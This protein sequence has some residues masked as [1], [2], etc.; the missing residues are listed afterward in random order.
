MQNSGR[1]YAEFAC[2]MEKLIYYAATTLLLISLSYRAFAAIDP[3]STENT[4]WQYAEHIRAGEYEKARGDALRLLDMSV[5]GKDTSTQMRACSLI[6]QSY[7]ATDQYDSTYRYFQMGMRLW[8]SMDSLSRTDDA[9]KAMCVIYNGL[10]IYSISVERNYERAISY[11]LSGLRLTDKSKEMS[12]YYAIFGSNLVHSYYLLS[13][14]TGLDY[15]MEVYRHGKN[16]EDPYILHAG[17]YS[18]ALMY[19]LK[20]DTDKALTFLGE[21]F[22]DDSD[23]FYKMAVYCLYADLL[24]AKGD[25]AEALIWYR[26]ALANL[27][28]NSVT[29]SISVYKSYGEFLTAQGRYGEAADILEAGVRLAETSGNKVYTYRLYELLSEDYDSLGQYD[30]AL[31]MF[32]KFYQ[33]TSDINL[34]EQERSVS[35]LLRKYENEKH[36][37][38]IQE[39]NLVIM[40]RSRELMFAIFIIIIV[41]IGLVALLVIYRH[42]NR[43]YT[44]I[45]RQYKEALEREKELQEKISDRQS[46]KYSNSSLTDD[47]NNELYS[48]LERLMKEERLY[49]D[50][51]LTR[52]KVAERLDSNRTYISQVVNNRTG[53]SFGAWLNAYRI[54]EAIEILSDKNN[55][56]PLKALC[57]ELGFNTLGTFYRLFTEKVGM[58]PA[59]YR[60]IIRQL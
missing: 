22:R 35:S 12:N 27:D 17:C 8:D 37:R 43:L 16:L 21:I 19:Y 1:K 57:Q 28:T 58:P 45:V 11:F 31:E 53:M 5:S 9:Y 32:R 49:R 20:G 41:L 25:T 54:Q 34:L 59:K 10:G 29:T 36:G 39:H 23:V 42:K 56:I 44:Q 30:R 14:T 51:N 26:K 40:K 33:E 15:A 48:R 4:V 24:S 3:D 46:E 47:K 13:D 52:E 38:E 7:L 2:A 50:C 60:S 18:A 55:D 6:G